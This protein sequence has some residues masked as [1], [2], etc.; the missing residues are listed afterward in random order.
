M[1]NYIYFD[2]G[3]VVIKD[4]S[5]TTKWQQLK[6]DLGIQP[7]QDHDFDTFFATYEQQICIDT[8]VEDLVPL[9][10]HKFHLKLPA[11]YSLLHDFVNRFEP[12]T[13]IWP[14]VSE[15]SIHYKLGLLTNMYQGMFPA[16]KDRG[17][18]PPIN[19]HSI[20]DSSQVGFAKPD[21]QIYHL[22]QTKA[23]TDPSEILFI[24]NTQKHLDTAKALS[25][26]TFW[27]NASTPEQSSL[28]LHNLISS[29]LHNSTK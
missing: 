26:Q 6:R 21:P 13:S 24:D 7:N 1:I 5:G 12:N 27:Y 29:E 10:T 2:V 11:N 4:F 9:M 22:A 17:L 15:A 8:N 20:I 19:W 16:I 28:N 14:V 25:W 18:L 23:Q 3:G